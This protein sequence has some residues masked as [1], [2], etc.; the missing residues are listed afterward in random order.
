MELENGAGNGAGNG[1]RKNS[2]ERVF[3]RYLSGNSLI[4]EVTFR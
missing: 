1:A 3:M 4:R 2:G